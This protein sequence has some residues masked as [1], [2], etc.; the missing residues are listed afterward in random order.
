MGSLWTA[1][2]TTKKGNP[3]AGILSLQQVQ[4]DFFTLI[5]T[6]EAGV[7]RP[8]SDETKA[9]YDSVKIQVFNALKDGMTTRDVFRA[10]YPLVQS[11]HDAHF[12]IHLPDDIMEDTCI[13]FFPARV[14]ID[15]DRLYVRED[16]SAGASMKNGTEIY[17]INGLS[18][19]EIIQKIRGTAHTRKS[20]QAF[21]EYRNEAVFHRRL[22]ALWEFSDTF[23]VKTADT[24]CILPGIAGSLLQAKPQPAYE[25]RM[26]SNNTG[27]LK[28]YSLLW[29]TETQRDSLK[30]W[31]QECF[32]TLKQQSAGQLVIDI[33]GNLGGSSV[34]AKDILD[35]VAHG[36]YTLSA[37]VDYFHKGQRYS[38][39]TDS[40]HTPRTGENAFTGKVVLISDVLTYSSAHMM[41]VG[42]Q[43]FKMGITVGQESPESLYITGEIRKTVLRN[44]RVELIA[45]TVNFRLPGY[46]ESRTE[47]YVPDHVM[48]PTL[49]DRLNGT[50]V[51]LNKALDVLQEEEK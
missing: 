12:A 44:S 39:A 16:L 13:T 18:A 22:Y 45:P 49:A 30:N 36:P 23:E 48:Y 4:E 26:I 32:H 38:S 6:I 20:S 50:D 8:Y 15:G 29:T 51:L 40:M 37:G 19:G 14:I 7:P 42:F 5:H 47:Y 17:E 1:C 28:I 24:T 46:S 34:L 41:Q 21:F 33:R 10:F 2:S 25:F 31:L 43:H 3:A 11:L 9:V 27:Y 35:Y